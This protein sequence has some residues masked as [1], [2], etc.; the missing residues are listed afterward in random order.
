MFNI[1]ILHIFT[2]FYIYDYNKIIKYILFYIPERPPNNKRRYTPGYRG[3][4]WG[5]ARG[6]NNAEDGKI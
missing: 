4:Y 2:Y 3:G 6:K 5:T 1:H